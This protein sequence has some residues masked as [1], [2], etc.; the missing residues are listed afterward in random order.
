MSNFKFDSNF[1]KRTMYYMLGI[2]ILTLGIAVIY[3][4]E[5]LGVGSFNALHMGLS[6]AFGHSVG[7]WANV[8]GI[9]LLT[10]DVIIRRGMPRFIAIIPMF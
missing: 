1:V 9:G 4:A 6:E 10:A 2:L 3:K 5:S 7:F 8:C